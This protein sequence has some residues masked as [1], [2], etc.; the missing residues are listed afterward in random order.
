[1][2]LKKYKPTTPSRRAMSGQDFSLLTKKAPEKSLMCVIKK[3]A[4]KNNYGRITIRHR[5]GGVRK[6]YRI[7]DFKRNKD[8]IEAK[9]VAIEY[10]PNRNA[11]IALLVYADGEKRYI[12]ATTDMKVGDKVISGDKVEVQSGNAMMLKN[13]PFGTLIHNIE[14]VPGRGAKLVRGAG[15]YAQ[16]TSR[17]EKYGFVTLPSGEIRLI[18]LRC[19]ATVGQ[20]SN[21][22]YNNIEWGKAGRIRYLGKRPRVRGIAMNPIDHPHGGGEGR[23]K[24]NHP[25][26][27]WGVPTKGYKTRDKKKRTNKFIIK[28]R[29]K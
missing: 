13:I 7:I 18:D 14:L 23:S 19:R 10:D 22:E 8:N 15:N 21:I 9:V 2:A 11:F 5:G 6:K 26:T 28:R 1:M 24:G 16:M 20:I 29:K 12:L 25:Q 17:E 27:P 4:G 3:T